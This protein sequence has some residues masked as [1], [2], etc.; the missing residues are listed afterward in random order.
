[1][2]GR[3]DAA[4]VRE[5]RKPLVGFSDV[6][7]LL[8][9]QL[10]AAGL[11]GF[12]GPMFERDAGPSDAELERLVRAL[13]GEPLPPLRGRRA[14][15]RARRGPPR[16]RLAHA[17]RR[18]PRHAVG[19][20]HAR[21]DP[22]PS[23]RSARSPTRSTATL[24]HLDAAGKL[25]AAAGFA[26]GSLLGCDDPKRSA[27]TADEVVCE[28]LGRSGS[29]SSPACH[30]VTSSR[31]SSGPSGVRAQARRRNGGAGLARSG[32]GAPVRHAVIR[33]K[34]QKVD[35]ALD[36]R[37][38]RRRCRAPSCSRACGATA[39]WLEHCRCAGSR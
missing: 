8:L 12:H 30:S 25:A 32:S 2:V 36:R 29:R 39:S 14:P 6:T 13:A 33:R 5:A 26:V 16:R 18:E 23:R 17:A 21:R 11:A 34:L 38:K 9:W 27:P 24:S 15:R 3:L 1:M 35:R 37:S 7:T 10:R 22:L 19:D 4:R 28:I 31:T 20:R